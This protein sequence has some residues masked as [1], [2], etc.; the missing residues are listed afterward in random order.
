MGG[1][2]RSM[3]D[4]STSPASS[5]LHVHVAFPGSHRSTTTLLNH[6]LDQ[7]PHAHVYTSC[8]VPQPTS[9]STASYIAR[10]LLPGQG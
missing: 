4:F 7:E 3:G 8:I 2:G 5:P 1:F 9:L 10:P 6:T